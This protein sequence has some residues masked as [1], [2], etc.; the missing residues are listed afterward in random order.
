VL[1]DEDAYEQRRKG[2]HR[3]QVG[4]AR[5]VKEHGLF[6]RDVGDRIRGEKL[7]S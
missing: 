1:V 4:T 2:S 3:S 7:T 6:L 5:S